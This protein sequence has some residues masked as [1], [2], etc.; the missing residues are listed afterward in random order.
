MRSPVNVLRSLALASLFLATPGCAHKS[1]NSSEL[2]AE[3]GNSHLLYLRREPYRSLYVE[4]DA[5]KGS[6]PSAAELAQLRD[7]LLQWCDKPDGIIII[8][9]NRIPRTSARGYSANS[10]ARRFLDGPPST[11]GA[12][13]AFLYVL[14]YDNRLNRNP[15]QSPRDASPLK[16]TIPRA[17]AQSENPHVYLSPYPPMIYIDRSWFGGRAPRKYTDEFPVHEAAHVLGLVRRDSHSPGLHC[18]TQWC[19]M[20]YLSDNVKALPLY[21]A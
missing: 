3:I 21:L 2:L 4:V 11:S 10:L 15:A 1:Q 19:F 6:E 9:G 8:N 5:V 7:F 20:S 18:P 16:T 17:L 13:P 14:F 12:N